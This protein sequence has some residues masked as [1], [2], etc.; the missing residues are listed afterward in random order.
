L[1]DQALERV[2]PKEEPQMKLAA[3]WILF[4]LA[5]LTATIPGA[6]ANDNRAD[7]FPNRPVR[8]IVPFPPGGSN[9]VLARFL[10]AKL[11]ERL[12][13]QVVIDNRGGANGIIGTELAARQNPDGYTLLMVSTSFVMNAAVR[14][15]PYDVEKSFDPIAMVGSS[16]NSIVVPQNSPF[17]TVRDLVESAK[18]KPGEI[19]YAATGVGGF[20][21]FGGELFKKVAG[22]DLVMIAYKGGGPA[23]TDVMAGQVPIMFSSLT[24][25]LPNVRAGRLRLLAVGAPK[26]SPVVPDVP[27]V[28]ESGYPTYEVSV[29]WGVVAPA[30]VPSGTLD[31]LRR[32]IAAV[33]EDGQ[34]RQR[35]IADAAEPLTM[36]PA[37]MRRMIHA[38]VAKWVEVARVAGIR[39]P[40]THAAR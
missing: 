21:H 37:E 6:Y 29:W 30:G 31:K 32:E 28:A 40:G 11:T 8:W 1:R 23:M 16:P 14:P 33:L 35:L 7:E 19:N 5:G 34:T 26:R 20:N 39:I 13:Q 25:V 2:I 27:T 22:V 36:A 38:D 18:A 3:T 4:A 15:L 9:D 10:G 24:Q 12:R 17:H